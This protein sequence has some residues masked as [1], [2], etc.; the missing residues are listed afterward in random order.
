MAAKSKAKFRPKSAAQPAGAATPSGSFLAS[1][2]PATRQKLL[3]LLQVIVI[4]EAAF[5]VLSPVLKGTWYGDDILYI[6][7][8][9]LLH[10]PG[11]VWKAWFEPGTFIDYY[12]IE[13]TVQWFQ[14]TLFG[15]DSPYWYL[16]CN[17]ALHVTSALLLW[18]LFAKLGLRYAWLGGLIFA[19]Y[20]LMVDSIGTA[21]ELKNTL[22]LPPFLLAMAFYLDFEKTRRPRD[23]A[24]ALLLFLIAMLC[25]ITAFFF[26]IVILL[27]AWWK[28]G[29]I[30]WSDARAAA[31]FLV[32]S[33]TLGLIFLYASPTYAAATHYVS[34]GPIH[35]GGIEN[36]LELAGLCLAFYF[37]HAFLPLHPV[38]Y[39]PQWQIEPLTLL[40]FLPWLGI[41]LAVGYC[42]TRRDNWGRPALFALAF[43][44]LGLTPF[45]GL[46]EVSY[47]C[48]AW[49]WDHL[50]Y[51]PIIALIGLVIA[52]IEGIGDQLPARAR[53]AGMALVALIILLLGAQTH[54]YATRFA[55]Q[56]ELWRDNLDVYPDAWMVHQLYGNELSHKGD[57][58]GA[59]AQ[60]RA[61]LQINP[62]FDNA[63]MYLGLGLFKTGDF[64]GAE[65]AFRRTLQLNP[66]YRGAQMFL[67]FVLSRQ[68]RFDEAIAQ[69]RAFL[70][71]VPVSAE[72]HMGLGQ[73]LALQGHIPEAIAELQTA[74]KLDPTNEQLPS[75]IA[76]L[77]A[78]LK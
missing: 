64:S 21:S 73:T 44:A 34:P 56:E 13:Q 11:R 61:S 22:S 51:L 37:G 58:T 77:Q 26:P 27:F 3:L 33:L 31:P 70:K 6:L 46:N 63:A 12:P 60:Y 9:P 69:F 54:S 35:L 19:V 38:P 57:T 76:A 20:P 28:R 18:R 62:Y 78:R 72:G 49:V 42:W 43:F 48:L 17:L 75:Q 50:L 24:L 40:R 41:A 8:N 55:D 15:E 36:R 14:W 53:P 32:V 29:K 5:W 59:I 4:V 74:L 23:Y 67:G 39:Y 10:H 16:I 2:A 7:G 65:A 47:M 25:K 71:D 30:T 45:L 66:N 52:T 68:G 1:L